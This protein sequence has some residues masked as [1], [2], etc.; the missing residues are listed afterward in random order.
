MVLFE[1]ASQEELLKDP[2]AVLE[3]LRRVSGR[4][5]VFCQQGRIAVPKNDLL[6]FR[7]LEKAVVEV[8]PGEG[9]G[10]FHAKTWLMRF[11]AKDLTVI[12]RFL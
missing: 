8:N 2:I 12:H 3:A 1:C 4:F 9:N 7:Y 6:L 5:A 11:T 10:V